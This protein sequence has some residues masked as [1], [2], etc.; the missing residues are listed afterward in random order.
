[1]VGLMGVHSE[2]LN[3]VA[4]KGFILRG[5]KEIR[6]YGLFWLF[7]QRL[8]GGSLA[9]LPGERGRCCTLEDCMHNDR[10]AMKFR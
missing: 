3:G 6:A 9:L 1:M 8:A 10:V 4:D 5:C 7:S 2:G